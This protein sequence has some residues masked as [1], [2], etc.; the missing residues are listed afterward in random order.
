MQQN[1]RINRTI[2]QIPKQDFDSCALTLYLPT[3]GDK[4]QLLF[5]EC[6]FFGR[7]LAIGE[8]WEEDRVPPTSP[9][10]LSTARSIEGHQLS[11]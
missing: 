10:S 6:Q 11:E 7:G 1:V 8:E 5:S 3:F 2:L 4:L 9:H